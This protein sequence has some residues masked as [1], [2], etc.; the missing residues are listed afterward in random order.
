MWKFA[1]FG[2]HYDNGPHI[3]REKANKVVPA[4]ICTKQGHSSWHVRFVRVCNG[5]VIVDGD[6][7]I[8]VDARDGA[9][10]G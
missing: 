8:V 5:G 1:N 2:M 3:E 4:M 6:V 10:D 7:R 9:A